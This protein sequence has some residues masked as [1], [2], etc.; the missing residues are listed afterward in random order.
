MAGR[1]FLLKGRHVNR[2]TRSVHNSWRLSRRLFH[3]GPLPALT[4]RAIPRLL[5]AVTAVVVVLIT[6]GWLLRRDAGKF[7]HEGKPGTLLS[8]GLLIAGGMLSLRLWRQLRAWPHRFGWLALGVLLILAG[9]DDM[10]KLHEKTDVIINGWLGW[11]PQGKGDRIDDFLV[12]GYALP[13]ALIWLFWL[14]NYMLHF[15]WAVLLLSGGTVCFAAMVCMD[16]M[17]GFVVL[18]ETAKLYAGAL[19]CLGLLAVGHTHLHRRLTHRHPWSGAG[20]N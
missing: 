20:R 8:V 10:F 12:A 1:R 3:P 4:R 5:I 2:I 7:F 13:V 6:L 16:M 14:R 9:L 17:G 15:S 11:D 18:E 19:I